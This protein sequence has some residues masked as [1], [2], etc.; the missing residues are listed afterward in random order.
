MKKIPFVSTLVALSGLVLTGCNGGGSS[1]ITSDNVSIVFYHTFGQSIQETLEKKISEFQEI[2]SEYEGVTVNIT[3]SYAGSYD[4]IL[5]KITNGLAA[6]NIPTIAVAYP[7]HVADYLAAETYD[8]QYVVNLEPYMTNEEY[9]FATQDYLG[10]EYG[11]DDIIEAYYEEG[12]NYSKEGVYSL[13]LM[14]SSEVMFYNYEAVALALS[15]SSN[16][17]GYSPDDGASEEAVDNFLKNIT[18]DEFMDFCE[19]IADNASN[20]ATTLEVPAY[21]D[22]DSNLFI[23]KMYQ[24]NIPYASINSD[25]TG[26]IDFNDNGENLAAAKAMVSKL[27]EQY[28][29]GLF[30][31]KGVEGTYGS[32]N[33]TEVKSIFSIGSTG[34]TGYNIPTSDAFTVGV[35]KV[36][37]DND[38]PLYVSQGPTLCIMNNPSLST[39]ENEL[40]QEYAWKFIKFLTNA[41]NNV[42][43]CIN[44][45]NG[46]T[47]IRYSAYES[48]NFL[49]FLEAGDVYAQ[50]ALV[51]LD[52]IGENFV[53]SPAFKGSATL[54]DQGGSILT[55]VF[56][57]LKDVDTAFSDAINQ[58]LMAMS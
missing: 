26:S 31:T 47:P 32:N 49:A 6:G 3:L 13:A 1:T 44:G 51:T 54:R 41:D 46:Y 7:D 4:D 22:S 23:S 57:D 58:T 8:G 28:D 38:N 39:S 52:D 42:E 36:P 19:F 2:I 48:D 55:S 56:T 16:F 27:K 35:V 18:W 12:T 33:F 30:T 14:K 40:R 34:G 37:Y 24:N 43:L 5:T 9:G 20:I 50:T 17:E 25:G 29:A 53:S 21:Y 15:G 45:S 10:D 11:V